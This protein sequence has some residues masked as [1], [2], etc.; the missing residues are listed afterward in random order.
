[1][2]KGDL[3]RTFSKPVIAALAREDGQGEGARAL[4]ESLR[5][6]REPTLY[7]DLIHALTH[8]HFKEHDAR[9]H[10]EEILKHKTALSR[11]LGRDV[12]VTVAILDY[13]TNL[14]RQIENPKIIELEAYEESLSSTATDGLTGLYNH[15]FFQ[16]RLEEELERARR[17]GTVLSVVLYDLDDFKVYNDTNG[18]IAG[19]VLLLEAAKLIRKAIRRADIPARYGGDELAIIMPQTDA[20]GAIVIAERIRERLS[21]HRFPNQDILPLGLVTMSGGVVTFPRDAEDKATLL[22]KADQA[23]RKAKQDG[24]SRVVQFQPLEDEPE[25]PKAKPAHK[26]RARKARK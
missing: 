22:E 2:P 25:A 5:R 3:R 8:L 11:N 12:G 1:M 7:S 24:K 4:I 20:A 16:D 19:D 13:F 15:R 21:A 17:Y 23:L 26:P 18:H 6:E 9:I 10:W 14:H